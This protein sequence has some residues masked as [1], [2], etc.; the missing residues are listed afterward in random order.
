MGFKQN[1]S[2]MFWLYRSKATANDPAA[3]IYIRVTIDGKFKDISLGRKCLPADWDEDSKKVTGGGMQA[4]ITNGKI[5]QARADLDKHFMVLQTQ[6]ELVTPQMLKNVYNGLPA[7][8]TKKVAV[9]DRP[10]TQTLLEAF[11]E[12]IDKFAKKVEKK[13]RSAHTLRHWRTTRGKVA[14][15]LRHHYGLEDLTFAEIRSS[16][17]EDFYDY[18]TLEAEKPLAEVTARKEV[19]WTR[20]IVEMGVTREEIGRNPMSGFKC[21][22]GDKEVLPLELYEVEAI[23]SKKITVPRIAE[24]RDA[25]IF[26]CFTGF[27]YQDIYNLA[28]ENVV[29][30]GRTGERWLIKDRG[31]TDVAEMVPILP[32]VEE[33]IEKY[34]DHPYCKVHNR[35]MP[36]NSNYRYNAYLKELQHLCATSLESLSTRELNTHLARHTFADIMLNNGVPLEDVSKMLGHKSIRTTMRYCRVRKSRISENM[37]MI[38]EK[39]FTKA[40]KLRSVA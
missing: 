36:I 34:K 22:G 24:V 32:V 12:F 4:K 39:L 40:G 15:F 18:L 14:A 6:H 29:R 5:D 25:F 21:S 35:L 38:R 13:L 1:L 7:I 33:L 26:Q 16:F 31:K 30:V 27:A 28:P 8:A 2:I 11:D 20:Q 37:A 3:P 10:K 9:H 23:Y 17:A 19:K